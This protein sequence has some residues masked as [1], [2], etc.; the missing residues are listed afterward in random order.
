MV[1][2]RRRTYEVIWKEM[3][4]KLMQE[5]QVPLKHW[6]LVLGSNSK[7]KILFGDAQKMW[8]SILPVDDIS[9]IVKKKK[10]YEYSF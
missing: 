4:L 3:D 1:S 7:K 5:P 6:A 10:S 2:R 8:M 9:K